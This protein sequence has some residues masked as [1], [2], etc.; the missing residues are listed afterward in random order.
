[1]AFQLT[2]TDKSGIGVVYLE[3]FGFC[4]AEELNQGRTAA[5]E[6]IEDRSASR[7][8]VDVRALPPPSTLNSV[9]FAQ[10]HHAIIPKHV[11]VA[12]VVLAK[13]ASVGTLTQA[14]SQAAAINLRFFTSDLEAEHWLL[15]GKY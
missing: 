10:E 13:Y 15:C 4:G 9:S 8:F 3:H 5:M 11:H 14:I 12:I 1:M 2:Y 7:L 6:L